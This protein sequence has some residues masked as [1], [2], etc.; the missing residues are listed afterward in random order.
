METYTKSKGE[1][2]F[3]WF[4]EL[5]AENID[6]DKLCHLSCSWVTCA[7]GNQCIII[8]RNEEG[9]PTDLI[10][11][12]L[13]VDFNY[14]IY[15]RNKNSTLRILVQIESRSNELILELSCESK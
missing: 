5:N 13:G 2:P 3:N 1:E 4:K 15:H 7:C 6:W 11:Y 9:E 8:P 14:A 12:H 10:L